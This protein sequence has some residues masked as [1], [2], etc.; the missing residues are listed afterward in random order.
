MKIPIKRG[1]K[2]HKETSFNLFSTNC[3]SLKE[4]VKGFK[5]E[6]RKLNSSAFTLQETHFKTKGQFQHEDFEI[7]EAIRKGKKDGG[8]MIGVHKALKPIL[9]NEYDDPFEL[10]VVEIKVANREIRLMSGYGPQEYWTPQERLPFFNALEEEI[11]KAELAGKSVIIEA[12][13]NSKLG[14]EFIPKDPHEQSENNGKVLAEI[15]KRQRL[16]VANSLVKCKGTITRKRVTTKSTEESAISFVLVTEDLVEMIEEVNIDEEREH[17]LTRTT[18]TKKGKVTKESDHNVIE[19]KFNMKWNKSTKTEKNDLF[20]LKNKECQK[21]FKDETTKT[22][23][24]SKIFEDEKDLDVAT[25]KFLKKLNKI[26]HKCFRK[27]GSKKEKV[28]ET[29]EKIYNRWKSI[30]NKNEPKSV[31]ETAELEAL[32]ADDYFKKIDEATQGT[33]CE[34]GGMTNNKLWELKKK[35]FP[36]N[37]DPPTAM[38]DV[39]GNLVTD[40][41]KLK[42][43]AIDAFEKRLENR[44]IKEEL[45]EIRYLKEKLT[46]KLMDV[47]KNNK[48]PPW[49]MKDLER[50][51]N[52]LKLNKSRDPH[53]LANDIFRSDVAG[54]DLK[55]AL[56]ILMNR[57]KDEQ[58]YPKSLEL[59]NITAI[60]KK[61]GPRNLFQSY[62]GIFRVTIFRNILDRLIYNDEY[63]KIDEYLSDCN[64]G[65]RKARNVRDNI[66]V[67]NAILNAQ[68]KQNKE[69]LDL[70]VYDVE[71]CFDAL[72]LHEVINCLYEAGLQNDRLPLLFLENSNAQTAVKSSTGISERKNIRNIIMQGSVWGSLCC[73]V[74]MEKLGKHMYNNHE[75]MYYYKG[76]VAVP[77][78]QMVDDVLTI[79]K[80]SSQSPQVNTVV[81]TFMELEKL[82][83]SETKCHKLHIGKNRRNCRDLKV[84]DDELCESSQETYLGDKIHNSGNNQI[85]VENRIA[86]GYG[87]VNTILAMVKDAP[88]GW[89]RIKAGLK[90]RKAMLVNSM[91]FNSECW[92]GI[93]L[94]DIEKFEK[95]DEFLLKG[96]TNSHS[97]IPLPAL[98]MDLGVEPL[99][100]TWAARRIMYLHTLLTRD[101]TELTNKIYKA[102]KEDPIDGDFYKLVTDDMKMIEFNINEEDICKFGKKDLMKIVKMKCKEAAFKHLTTEKAS[103]HKM[104]HIEYT[105]LGTQPYMISPQFMRDDSSLLLSLRTRTVRGIRSDFGNMYQDKSCPLCTYTCDSLS[106][107][108]VCTALQKSQSETTEK[109]QYIDVFSN[110]LQVLRSI[111]THYTRLLQ[112]R[113]EILESTPD[114]TIPVSCIDLQNC[115]S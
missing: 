60:W 72:W 81:N 90:L 31:E 100:F 46:E 41:N 62:R 113:K 44:P 109:Y 63:A 16:T 102:Q 77:S 50:V 64:V 13:F 30:R 6:L 17:V 24:L 76:L 25:N 93:K 87:K 57:I 108:L 66:F 74:L 14:K 54:R 95:V 98:Y 43:M 8:T 70:Q 47:A 67:V 36:Q 49:E 26:L 111:T 114:T 61:K 59:C 56:L 58:Q 2:S 101:Q 27:I 112:R 21:V 42:E 94:A 1:R 23:D 86:K 103:K 75:L 40:E 7:F 48:T 28:D 51:L 5:C 10:L 35:L 88:L 33:T 106:H 82:K 38:K 29:F 68:R 34:E 110:D 104:D 55:K 22:N 71:T 9:I 45:S 84:H 19:T 80:C 85:N 99:R 4:K 3:A 73:V 79:T 89:W 15:I 78:L 20:N 18:K 32:L 92:H 12:D 65:A 91:L 69:P 107:V 11:I 53:G 39:K 52:H 105:H 83:L 115:D 37:R 97:K 96:L